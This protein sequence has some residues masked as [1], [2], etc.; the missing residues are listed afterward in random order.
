[1]NSLIKHKNI[2]DLYLN[3]IFLNDSEKYITINVN[4]NKKKVAF[5]A[6]V[7]QNYC[8]V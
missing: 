7:F 3:T 4:H 2:A 6:L 1:M 8:Q 5:P